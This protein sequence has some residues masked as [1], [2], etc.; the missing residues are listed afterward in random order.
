[1]AWIVGYLRCPVAQNLHSHY[2][3]LLGLT[4]PWSVSKVD[5]D[6]EA[7][8][9]VVAVQHSKKKLCC[10]DCEQ[11]CPIKDHAKPRQ[12]RHL[13]T[14]NFE[15]IIEA[16][17]PRTDCPECG[18]KT[19][20]VPWAGKHSR[21][22][23]MFEA[24]AVLVLETARTIE[25]A[26]T[27]LRLSWKCTQVIMKRAVVRGLE[28]RDLSEVSRVGIDEK[29]FGRGHDYISVLNDLDKGRVIDVTPERTEA[30]CDRL[31]EQS[32]TTDWSRF[33]IEA[34]ALDMWPAF[35]NSARKNFE[36]ADLVFDR[37]HVSQYLGKAVDQVR[38]AEH[39][40][41]RA[42]GDESLTGSKYAWLRSSETRT[43]KHEEILGKLCNK[44][45]KTSR[46]WAI[47]ESF[48][49]FWEAR[50]E[51]FAEG[52]FR[53]WYCWATRSQLEPIIKVAKMLK[54]H[55]Y[56]LLSYFKHRITNAVSEGINSKIQSIKSAARGFRNFENYRTSILFFCGKLT[57]RPKI[58][59]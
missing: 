50:N 8:Q 14:M 54:R 51:G 35:I 17:V 10:P 55:L 2:S 15:T 43:D 34:V 30:A 16:R 56:G 4:E 13:D 27:L 19:L 41:L 24:L 49:E 25:A 11:Q 40:A 21:F 52:I 20:P 6:L 57:L 46:A 29:N 12:W 45:L 26:R 31:I 22:T 5:L 9:V 18:V 47:K 42:Q 7:S 53:D 38:R 3:L 58:T 48:V 32:L 33:K 39:K 1:M 28:E 44:N 59:H 37:F 36:E 23:L